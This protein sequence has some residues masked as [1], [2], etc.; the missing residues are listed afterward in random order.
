MSASQPILIVEEDRREA[1][2][3]V[4]VLRDSGHDVR[5]TA[6]AASS[7]RR[8][9][10]GRLALVLASL[11]VPDLDAQRFLARCRALDDPPDV[12]LATAFGSVRESVAA[13]NAGAFDYVNKPLTGGEL[14]QVAERALRERSLRNEN[15]DLRAQLG[16]ESSLEGMVCRDPHM[17]Q[18]FGLARTVAPTRATVLLSGES[19][20]GKSL[21]ARAIHR[22]SDRAS[23][24]FVTVSCGALP[25][26][27]LESELFGHAKGSFTGAHRAK[28][29]RF[30]DADNGTL[31]LDEVA[32]ASPALQVKLLRF[33]QDRSFERVGESSTRMAD[34]RLI[35]ATNEDLEAAVRSGRFRED[36]YYRIHVI[37]LQL[38]PLRERPADVPPL[39][40]RLLERLARVHGRSQPRV[41]RAAARRLLE[42]PWPGN[43]RELEN[44]LERAL[45]LSENGRLDAEHLPARGAAQAAGAQSALAVPRL[46][47]KGSYS[48]KQLLEEPE[49]RIILAALEA[50]SGNRERTAQLLGINR[51]TLFAKLKRLG[52]Q[53]AQRRGH[54]A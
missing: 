52:L 50:C 27:L 38:R 22:L 1:A 43:V 26:A 8:L 21:M 30:E 34:V 13:K 31:F 47:P 32:L 16:R 44:A 28:S 20:T 14:L 7:L 42:Y 15:R 54:G 45:L 19:G 9:E 51:A 48:L 4:R 6:T 24:P 25:E 5:S 23:R 40:R 49:R 12:V 18:I 36:L 41:E 3:M 2:R 37:H 17:R 29:G 35:L 53:G 46:D 11:Q 10:T 39:A 33:L